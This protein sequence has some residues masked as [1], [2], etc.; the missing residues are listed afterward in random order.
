MLTNRTSL[1]WLLGPPVAYLAALPLA[2]RVEPVVLGLPFLM[3]WL[4][5]ATLLSPLFVWL[6]AKGDPVWQAAQ[7]AERDEAERAQT[8]RAQTER[9]RAGEER[10]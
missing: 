8:E 10:G 6:A 2:N 3:F 4:L 9:A 1:W 7:R 5:V